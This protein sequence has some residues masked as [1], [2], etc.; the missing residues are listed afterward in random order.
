MRDHRALAGAVALC[1]LV[2]LAHCKAT[3]ND[4]ENTCVGA[5]ALSGTFFRGSSLPPKTLALTFDDGPG[6]RTAELSLYL[7][8]E[9]IEAAFFVNGMRIDGA[10]GPILQGLIDDGHIVANHTETHVSLT[11]VTDGVAR[12]S[13]DAV[14]AE[15]ANTDGKIAP[16]VPSNRFLFRPPFGDYDGETFNALEASP[17]SK[18]VG[19]ISWDVGDRMDEA[20]GKAADWDCW[21]DGSDAKRLTVQQCGDL[22]LT[23]IR[24]QGRGIVLMHD[25]YV[26]DVT[27]EGTVDMVKYI[28]PI[29]KAEGFQFTRVDRVPDIEAVLP[30]LEGGGGDG[31][32]GNADPG[33]PGGPGGAENVG[34]NDPCPP[35]PPAETGTSMHGESGNLRRR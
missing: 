20:N 11:G 15:L 6:D 24:R 21:Q 5:Q 30:P 12:P 32:A 29:L 3:T 17:M 16:F 22:Y 8:Q 7:K 28:V 14:V 25:P 4:E 33:A 10:A 27:L 18:Y 13:A 34:G 9:G 1:A 19:P 35:A 2:T 31:G 23:E 26:D